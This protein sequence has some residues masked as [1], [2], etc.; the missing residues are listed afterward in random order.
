MARP[1]LFQHRKFRTLSR[2]VKSRAVAVG[3]LELIWAVANESGD[4]LIGAAEDVED[5]AD[6]RGK[7]GVLAAALVTCGFLDQTPDGLVVHDHAHH[8]PSYVRR[9]REREHARRASDAPVTRQS[10][11]SDAPL[12]PTPNS[13]L[14]SPISPSGGGESSPPPVKL[15][16]G[17]HKSHALCGYICLPGDLFAEFVRK[18]GVADEAGAQQYVSEWF[19]RHNATLEAERPAIGDDAFVFWRTRWALDHPTTRVSARELDRR[20]QAAELEAWARGGTA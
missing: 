10:R 16:H 14:P 1:S 8:C 2:L 18:C 3:S 6:W 11:A 9:R 12:T 4:P 19:R 13:P 20:K 7:P 17:S 5:V 15:V